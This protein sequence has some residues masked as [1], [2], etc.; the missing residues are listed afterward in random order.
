M[1]IQRLPSSMTALRVLLAVAEHGTASAAAAAVNLTQSAVSKH[2]RGLEETLGISLFARSNRGL[3]PTEAGRIYVKHV[4]QALAE[5]ETGNA[6]VSALKASPWSVRLHVL[7]IIGD[8][9]LVP[10]FSRFAERHPEIDVQFT[11]FVTT[12]TA[13]AADGVFRFGE[14]EW[15]G[16]QASYLFGRDVAL[17]GAASFVARLG[18]IGTAEDVRRYTVLD[19]FQTPLHWR[20]FAEA[21]GL[22]EF[23]PVHKTR[24]GF[25]SLVIRAA[26]AGQGLALVPRRLVQ[27]E[28]E[29]GRLV[30]PAGLGFKS[31]N[32]YWFTTPEDR[33]MRPGL[34]TFRNWLM[35]EAQMS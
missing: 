20:E 23:M 11:T 26:I 12:D 10:R 3:V 9:W 8:R 4:R 32:A 28:L 21:H 16:H 30:N 5:L 27:E 22:E 2:L 33:P 1:T 15:S 7:P 19:H 25:Y 13:E 6:Q 31:R 17:V 18:G 34:K 29:A 35:E 14:G 24:F